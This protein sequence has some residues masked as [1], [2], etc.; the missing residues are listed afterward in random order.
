MMEGWQK[1]FMRN[2]GPLL[3]FPGGCSWCIH[4]RSCLHPIECH[5]N[6]TNEARPLQHFCNCRGKLIIINQ[7]LWHGTSEQKHSLT[8]TRANP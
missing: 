1:L 2:S 3:L 8:C 5:G 7:I 6:T 4:Q